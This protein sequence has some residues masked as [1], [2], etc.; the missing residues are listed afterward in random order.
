MRP[1]IFYMI[2][3]QSN[4][5][6]I[7][8]VFLILAYGFYRVEDGWLRK[9]L[10]TLFVAIAW[11]ALLEGGYYL[12]WD[13]KKIADWP[14]EI[15]ILSSAPLVAAGVLLMAHIYPKRGGRMH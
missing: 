8:I 14:I 3:S 15:R 4:Y 7:T 5:I 1:S 13:I 2:I 6:C 12:I 10:I 11:K 9:L